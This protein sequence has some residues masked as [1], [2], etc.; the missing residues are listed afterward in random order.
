MELFT[1][2]KI[3]LLLL[4]AP[5]FILS[6]S[7]HEYAHAWSANRLGDSTARYLGRM[8]MDPMSHISWFGTVLFPAISLL[9]GAPLFG[10]ANP[11]PV[12]M[13][14]FRKPRSH[15]A[16]VAAAGPASNIVL[17]VLCTAGL[18]ALIHLTTGAMGT[19]APGMRGAAI[20]MLTMAVQLNLFL[21][22][23]NLLP[24]PPLDGSRIVQGFVSAQTADFIDRYAFQGQM[25]LLALFIFGVLRVLAVPVYGFQLGLFELFGLR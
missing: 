10:W 5:V 24:V 13:R 12:D 25:I 17:A 3:R 6:L 15:M 22:F 9:T 18:S 23:F 1:P 20:E 14:N 19:G 4:F 8:T 16:I 11:V 21:A 7:F 2:E